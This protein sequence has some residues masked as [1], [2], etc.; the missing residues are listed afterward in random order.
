M[1][2]VTVGYCKKRARDQRE[3]RK[4]L[5]FQLNETMSDPCLNWSRYSELKREFLAWERETLKGY[6]IRSRVESMVE[7]EPSIFHVKKAK[8]NYRKSTITKLEINNEKLTNNQDINK[9][10][11]NHFS[12]IFQNQP[13]PDNTNRNLFLEGVEGALTESYP[14]ETGKVQDKAAQMINAQANDHGVSSS[15]PASGIGISPVEMLTL[16][17]TVEELRGALSATKSNKSPGTDGIP[18]EFY[19]QFWDVIGPHFLEMTT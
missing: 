15:S 11:I 2:H 8:D 19:T 14:R 18:Y 13:E 1:K 7:E 5:Q 17:L 6:A 9:C 10:I 3:R 16:P 4:L 12:S